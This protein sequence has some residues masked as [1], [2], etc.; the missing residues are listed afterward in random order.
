MRDHTHCRS[1]RDSE[2][3]PRG[4]GAPHHNLNALRTGHHA[5][6]L[7]RDDLDQ[8]VHSILRTP[9]LLPH[10][11]D[12]TA[13]SIHH[14]SQDPVKALLALQTFAHSLLSRVTYDLFIGEL[15]TVLGEAPPDGTRPWDPIWKEEGRWK[16]STGTA[17]LGRSR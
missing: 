8:L 7:T 12:R 16:S 10:H 6:P 5:H 9:D 11:L 17:R 1:H 13:Q 4:A 3:R 2:L 14:R 15:P